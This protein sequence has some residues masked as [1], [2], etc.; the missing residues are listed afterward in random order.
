MASIEFIKKNYSYTVKNGLVT[1]SRKDNDRCKIVSRVEAEADEHGEYEK[2]RI[3][4]FQCFQPVG[5]ASAGVPRSGGAG[6][7]MMLHFLM[8]MKEKN[9]DIRIV[10][11]TPIAHPDKQNMSS[12]Q[13]NEYKTDI[14][15]HQQKLEEYYNSLGFTLYTYVV[16]DEGETDYYRFFE[17][18]IDYIIETID[19]FEKMRQFNFN[20]YVDPRIERQ[21]MEQF[22]IET[23]TRDRSNTSTMQI[24][25]SKYK[26]KSN[27][28]GTHKG[29][30]LNRKPLIGRRKN[31]T[32]K[33]RKR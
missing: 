24:G 26:K 11:L 21:M 15:R 18:N 27:K 28:S 32:N 22:G 29:G 2:L 9:P 16:Q 6:R 4:L 12:S 19:N 1:F 33:H 5:M 10:Y 17:G 30:N 25:S 13:Q 23:T 7:E 31:K 3:N 14:S 8:Y 20:S